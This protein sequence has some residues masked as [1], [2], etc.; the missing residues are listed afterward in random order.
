M[1]AT[2][3]LVLVV[4]D[5]ATMRRFLRTMLAAHGF[6]IEDTGSLHEAELVIAREAPSAIL[7]DLNLPDGDGVGLLQR[8]RAWSP[9]P[10]IVVSAR[11]REDE[12]V[13]AFEA[14]ADDYVTKPFGTT[15]LVA[16]LRVALR[17]ARGTPIAPATITVGSISIDQARHQVTVAGTAVHLTPIEFQLLA[18]LARRAGQIVSHAELIEAVWGAGKSHQTHHLRVHMAALRRKVEVEAARPRHILTEPGVG[19]RLE[20]TRSESTP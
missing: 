1:S 18:T 17:H 9:I 14:G 16:R 15:E 6:R 11:E 13:R 8:L 2:G 10:V 4:E 12:K 3:D 5:D 20:D 7:L 19:Y